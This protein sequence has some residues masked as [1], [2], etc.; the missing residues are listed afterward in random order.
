VIKHQFD[1]AHEALKNNNSVEISGFGKFLFNVKKT[2][3]K[4]KKLESIK[5]AYEKK[6]AS[7]E[8]EPKH[9]ALIKS[10]LS[11]LIITLNS[12]KPKLDNNEKA[13]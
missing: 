13:I 10:K 3:K 5:L 1:S 6:I 9:E 2:E 4:I 11:A 7:G 8:L 12:L